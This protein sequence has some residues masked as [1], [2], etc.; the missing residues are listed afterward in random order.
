M[1]TETAQEED[2][3]RDSGRRQPSRN[4]GS[5]QEARRG[6]GSD[7]P[8][9]PSKGTNPIDTLILD[10]WPQKLWDNTFCCS[11][12]PLCGSTE[13]G[14]NTWKNWGPNSYSDAPKITWAVNFDVGPEHGT[15]YPTIKFFVLQWALS[16]KNEMTSDTK[17]L[18]AASSRDLPSTSPW[19]NK[20]QGR[21]QIARMMLPGWSH[22]YGAKSASE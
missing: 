7:P 21:G 5:P 22:T 13:L 12:H 10:F 8:P 17:T 4:Q 3:M 18:A 19:Q 6:A 9:Q 2:S 15:S 14:L 16:K 1:W 11:S 20:H